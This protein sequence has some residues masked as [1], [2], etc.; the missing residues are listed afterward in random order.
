[1]KTFIGIF[2]LLA[3]M[4]LPASAFTSGGIS[5]TGVQSKARPWR[6]S[7]CRYTGSIKRWQR[8]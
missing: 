7:V 3:A 5:G 2:A 6:S 8:C 4:V 1:M